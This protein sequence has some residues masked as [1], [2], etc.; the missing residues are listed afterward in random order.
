MLPSP[1]LLEP[2]PTWFVNGVDTK[3]RWSHGRWTRHSRGFLG[4]PPRSLV[5][6]TRGTCAWR[7]S[8]DTY[9]DDGVRELKTYAQVDVNTD[10]YTWEAWV[11]SP[12]A[13]MTATVLRRI[14][15]KPDPWSRI[16]AASPST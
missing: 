8:N 7:K 4:S 14:V 11:R 13:N 2:S 16:I 6:P 9:V 12:T 5:P 15:V 3:R 1:M 10:L